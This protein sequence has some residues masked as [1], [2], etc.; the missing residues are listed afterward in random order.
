VFLGC[1]DVDPHIP[2]ARVDESAE[3]FSRMGAQVTRRIYPGIGHL[4]V[5]D[6]ITAARA[7][8][9]GLTGGPVADPARETRQ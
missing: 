8:L 6:E 5:P 4:I 3:V 7:I 2:R 9:D 1:S